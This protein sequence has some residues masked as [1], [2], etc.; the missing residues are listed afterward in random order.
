MK[1][2]PIRAVL[3]FV[4]VAVAVLGIGCSDANAWSDARELERKLLV[5]NPSAT[6]ADPGYLRVAR[7]LLEVPAG[8]EGY[9][10]A[11]ALLVKIQDAR[12]IQLGETL[13]LD[14]LPARLDGVALT[15]LKPQTEGVSRPT[16]RKVEAPSAPSAPSA[17]ASADDAPPPSSP[18]VVQAPSAKTGP[19]GADVYTSA[20][21]PA[22][23]LYSTSWCGYCS[24][25]RSWFKRN[26]IAF[27]E[28]D[29]EQDPAA[30]QELRAKVGAYSGVPVIDV[31]GTIVRGF[32]LPAIKRALAQGGKPEK[33]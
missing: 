3:T 22:V 31:G 21:Q 30:T 26:G 20:N 6:Y 33:L 15:S 14:Y 12:R 8:A 10:E 25:A 11:Q 4:L 32:D 17:V 2:S 5:A 28:K 13:K 7:R 19:G 18:A 1:T 27:T 24:K 16:P 23:I 9:E 29:V